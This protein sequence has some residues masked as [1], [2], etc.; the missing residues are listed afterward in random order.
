MTHEI[1]VIVLSEH[2]PGQE[3]LPYYLNRTKIEPQQPKQQQQQH[4]QQKLRENCYPK[5]YNGDTKHS[6]LIKTVKECRQKH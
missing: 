2:N 1:H 3:I 4:Q 5:L 6:L